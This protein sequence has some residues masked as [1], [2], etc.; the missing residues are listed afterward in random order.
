MKGQINYGFG[1][2]YLP[3]WGVKEAKEDINII[4]KRYEGESKG[5]NTYIG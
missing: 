4:I 1:R 5:H 3:K 2:E